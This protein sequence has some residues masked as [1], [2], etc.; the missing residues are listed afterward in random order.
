MSEY[1]HIAEWRIQEWER[2]YAPL[3]VRGEIN[4]MINW[5]DANP[6]RRKKNYNRF[7]IN[8]LNKAHAQI[9]VAQVNA[10]VSAGVGKFD[11]DQKESRVIYSAS[12]REYYASLG[13]KV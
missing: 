7:V 12:T 5:L 11:P 8:W 10:R 4:K 9:V 6:R 2:D 3:N 1:F 13:I